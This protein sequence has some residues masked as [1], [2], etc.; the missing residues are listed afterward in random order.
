VEGEVI[1]PDPASFDKAIH[2]PVFGKQWT[3]GIRSELQ[4]LKAN[5]TW[6]VVPEAELPAGA[7]VLS[8][9]WVFKTKKSADGSIRHK[10]RLVVRGY[11]QV[12]GIDYEETFAPVARLVSL[13]MLLALA[14][15]NDWEIEQ[16]D[17]VTAFLNPDIDG[18]VYMELPDGIDLNRSGA[19]SGSNNKSTGNRYSG[20]GRSVVKLLKALYGLKQA[21]RLWYQAIDRFLT[22]IKF[23]RCEYD[24][25]VY[26]SEDSTSD[27]DRVIILLYVDDLLLFSSSPERIR[28]FKE[29]LKKQYQMTDLGPVRKFLGLEIT[30]N[31]KER[32]LTV[33]Q[34]QKIGELLAKTQMANCH[35][36]WTPLPTNLE[37]EPITP[38]SPEAL[39][40]LGR[41]N[42]QSVV[43]SLMWIMLGTRPDLA[44]TV[45]TLSKFNATPSR[46]HEAAAKHVLRYLRNTSNC[47]ITFNGSDGPPIGFSDSDFAGDKTDRKSTSG[48]VFTLCGGAIS[49]RA[50]KQPLVAFSTVEAEYIGASDAS[51]EAF[52]IR[53]LYAD[54][55]L[56]K[57]QPLID[58]SSANCCRNCEMPLTVT[59]VLSTPSTAPETLDVPE[60]LLYLDNQGAMELAKNPRFHERTKHINIRYHFVRDACERKA[61]R[62][63]Y[64]ATADMTADIMTKSLPRET[65]WRHTAGMGIH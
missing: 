38:D 49:W 47:G 44:F 63:N 61:L 45:A 52:W 6:S 51:K 34:K 35:G 26:I 13:R 16:M 17:V 10:A 58:H 48:Y 11:E 50:R 21:P 18:E 22:S 36:Q 40:T 2:H 59:E 41:Q 39:D 4:S 55:A 3:E 7:H 20:K 62:I 29:I 24:P 32:T 28:H 33:T 19:G 25:N 57:R 56:R 60:Q 15:R 27:A 14:A 53:N 1:E 54:T 30:R 43:G 31:R 42:Y 37:L 9:K 8:S 65:H 23:R 46:Q 12:S 5:K 64:I